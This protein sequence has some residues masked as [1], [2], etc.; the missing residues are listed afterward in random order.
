VVTV[1][2]R[3][4]YRDERYIQLERRQAEGQFGRDWTRLA[5][6]LEPDILMIEH[7]PDPTDLADLLLLA[8]AGMTV[9]CGIRRVD[10]DRTL[11]TLLTLEVDPFI[12]ANVMRLAVHQRLV[13]LLCLSCRRLVPARPS[14]ASVSDRYRAELERSLE[15][16]AFFLPSGCPK[17]QGTGYSGKMAL[18]ELL[19]FTPGVQ[20]TVVSEAGLEQKVS[21][22]LEED[23]YP[24][25]QTVHDLL[26]RG[27]VTYDE[28]Q[29]FF[30]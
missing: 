11:R 30:R 27:M 5:E 19:P 28:V 7:L 8:Q 22:L 29:P 20:N 10:F 17:C 25:I 26:R 13:Q 16:T 21:L 23:F 6:S 12:L 18:I 4:R 15:E 24:A 9:L 3:H 2:E 1:E 14:L